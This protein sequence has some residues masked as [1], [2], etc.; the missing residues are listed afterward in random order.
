MSKDEPLGDD[1]TESRFIA[2][3]CLATNRYEDGHRLIHHCVL[4]MDADL[5][6]Y[7]ERLEALAKI[8]VTRE[9]NEA[10]G[11]RDT[12]RRTGHRSATGLARQGMQ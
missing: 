7:Q 8:R 1:A 3:D 5:K 6:E 11:Q 4:L 2:L 12:H 9:A 10:L